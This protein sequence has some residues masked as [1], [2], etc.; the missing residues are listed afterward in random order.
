MEVKDTPPLVQTDTSTLGQ[1]INGRLVPR[2]AFERAQ[3]PGFALLVPGSHTATEGSQN[4]TQ[5][6]RISVNAPAS[7]RTVSFSKVWDN[8]DSYMNQYVALPSI[9]AIQEFKVQ[10]GDYSAEFGRERRRPGERDPQSGA[11]QFHGGAFEFLRNRT[12][13]CPELLRLSGPATPASVPGACG[14]IPRLDRNQFGAYS[15]RP[16]PGRIRLSSL[17]LYEGLRLRQATTR[18]SYVPSQVQKQEA[19]AGGLRGIP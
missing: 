12:L 6:G 1:V 15:R 7:S 11:N 13:G 5:G 17:W 19:L 2:V 4:S 14:D 18:G 8:N 10:S 16:H 9:D 3:F